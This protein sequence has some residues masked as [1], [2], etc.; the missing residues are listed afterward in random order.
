MSGNFPKVTH[1]LSQET[2]QTPAIGIIYGRNNASLLLRNTLTRRAPQPYILIRDLVWKGQASTN[3]SSQVQI[4][5]TT[6]RVSPRRN[7]P[8]HL[9]NRH[10]TDPQDQVADKLDFFPPRCGTWARACRVGGHLLVLHPSFHDVI[11]FEAVEEAAFAS[12]LGDARAVWQSK[13]TH[14]P[15]HLVLEESKMFFAEGSIA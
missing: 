12:R 6:P 4:S 2:R 10:L 14:I 11:V 15:L 1:E 13:S 8:A 9:L 7:V 5:N 3:V